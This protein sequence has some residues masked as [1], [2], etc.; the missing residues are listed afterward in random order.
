MR[1][2]SPVTE[3]NII[4]ATIEFFFQ[5]I[6]T[7]IRIAI[8]IPCNRFEQTYYLSVID[9]FPA[10]RTGKNT[11]ILILPTNRSLLR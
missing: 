1:K 4:I 5:I 6:Y 10:F 8:I 9:S 3:K 2:N 11:T 7:H